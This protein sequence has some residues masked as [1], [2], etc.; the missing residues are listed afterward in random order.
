MRVGENT[1]AHG[2]FWTMDF[3]GGGGNFVVCCSDE[4]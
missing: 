1:P 2:A 4:I 3:T